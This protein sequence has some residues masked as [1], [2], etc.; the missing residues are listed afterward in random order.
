MAEKHHHHS[1]HSG[2]SSRSSHNSRSSRSGHRHSSTSKYRHGDFPADTTPIPIRMEGNLENDDKL[3]LHAVTP[4]QRKVS[5][6]RKRLQ[7]KEMN[8]SLLVLLG[9]L[10]ICLAAALVIFLSV[11]L[12]DRLSASTG[13][14]TAYNVAT[15]EQTAPATTS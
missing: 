3:S 15:V 5:H 10:G 8:Q 6:D 13:P 14:Q 2:R 12:V 9:I 1:S 11:R 4:K 7:R